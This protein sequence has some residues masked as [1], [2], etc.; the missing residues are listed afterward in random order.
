MKFYAEAPARRGRQL[1][2]DLAVI[3]W[4]Y[5][6]VWLAVKLYDLVEK[7]AVPGQKMEDAGNGISGNL[8]DAGGKVGDIPGI[9]GKLAEPFDKAAQAGKSLADAGREQQSIV[10]DMAWVLALLLLMVPLALVLL[11]WLPLRLR[12]IRRASAAA[13]LRG[14]PGGADLL[15][16]RALA[17]QPLRRL[18]RVDTDPVAAWRRGDQQVVTDLA[19]LELRNLGLR[20]RAKQLKAMTPPAE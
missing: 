15:A 1:L 8:S 7:L 17:N 16:L 9:G 2:T 5:V 20:A 14:G 18:S 4:V 12:W 19:G 11:V 10:H 6:W 3:V 13:M